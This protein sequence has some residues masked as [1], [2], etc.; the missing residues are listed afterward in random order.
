LWIDVWLWQ[1]EDKEESEDDEE[2]ETG[3]TNVSEI[4]LTCLSLG[5]LQPCN[6]YQL[7]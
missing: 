2:W 4:D 1:E 5:H 3:E 7:I 6:N